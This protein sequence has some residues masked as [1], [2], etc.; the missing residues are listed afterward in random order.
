MNIHIHMAAIYSCLDFF[1]VPLLIPTKYLEMYK[2]IALD[3]TGEIYIYTH[4]PKLSVSGP[5]YMMD[6][7]GPNANAL[8]VLHL[9]NIEFMNDDTKRLFIDQ[10]HKHS[11]TLDSFA[12]LY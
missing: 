6:V 8:L 1:G 10:L 5:W 7:T 9:D 4:E 2:Y 11:F 3:A 12:K